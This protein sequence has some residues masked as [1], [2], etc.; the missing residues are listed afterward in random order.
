MKRER[1]KKR[2]RSEDGLKEKVFQAA[3]KE[4]I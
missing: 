2:E 3:V 4:K 1:L